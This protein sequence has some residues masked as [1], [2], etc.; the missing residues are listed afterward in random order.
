VRC[1][2]P[3]VDPLDSASAAP[4]ATDEARRAALSRARCAFA[5]HYFHLLESIEYSLDAESA[6]CGRL[7][8]DYEIFDF[9]GLSL[10]NCNVTTLRISAKLASAFAQHYP[11]TIAKTA[12]VNL[13]GWAVGAMNM[14]L[15]AMPQRV[16]E[17][18]TLL[19]AGE[20]DALLNDLDSEAASLLHADRATLTRHRG[21]AQL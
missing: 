16:R 11:E 8:R 14:L 7:L 3:P 15:G 2:P 12:V 18:V 6:A 5:E 10:K 17:R 9:A 21:A 1:A 20:H 19:A 13:P 4:R